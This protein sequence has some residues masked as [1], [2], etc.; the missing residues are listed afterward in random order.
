M[1]DNLYFKPT[2]CMTSSW[3]SSAT[4]LMLT[5]ASY[6]ITYCLVGLGAVHV[7]VSRQEKGVLEQKLAVADTSVNLDKSYI[8][9][10]KH[11]KMG[12]KGTCHYCNASAS[13]LYCIHCLQVFPAHGAG[14]PCGKNLS[15][16]LF[17]T[18]GQQ[19]L[20]NSALGYTDVCTCI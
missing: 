9:Y 7:H 3:N 12:G 11:I 14:S 13:N 16:D 17:S 6:L 8:V 15:S 5:A 4:S 2:C 20:T 19:R 10:P 18:I 1:C